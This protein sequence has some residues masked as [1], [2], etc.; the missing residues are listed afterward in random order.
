MTAASIA[1][2]LGLTKVTINN[3]ITEFM[4]AKIFK[5]IDPQPNLEVN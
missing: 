2:E 5:G 4:K 1:K 3:Q